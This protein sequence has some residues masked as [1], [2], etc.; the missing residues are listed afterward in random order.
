MHLHRLA[1]AGIALVLITSS[2]TLLPAQA[3]QNL[4]VCVVTTDK[5]HNVQA[6]Y[7]PATGDT[8]V[9]TAP[10][11]SVHRLHSGYAVT[12]RWYQDNES[13][14]WA[15]QVY[16]R[17]G[18][19]LVIGVNEL[20]MVGVTVGANVYA[21]AGVRLYGPDGKMRPPTVV[22]IPVRPGCEFHRYTLAEGDALVDYA[23]QALRK[24]EY[25]AAYRVLSRPSL[26]GNG[27]A[28]ARLGSLYH[29]ARGVAP[30][31]AA[32][33][34]L[35]ERAIASKGAEG[36]T[37]R[38]RL[39]AGSR[40][41]VNAV[42]AYR[43]GAARGSS[44]SAL[45][46]AKLHLRG[47]SGTVD[48]VEAARML[49][50]VITRSNPKQPHRAEAMTALSRLYA[51][52]RGIDGDAAEWFASDSVTAFQGDEASADFRMG[53]RFEMGWATWPD[54]AQAELHYRRGAQAGDTFSQQAATRLGISYR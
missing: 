31:T 1:T 44:E 26:A 18:L 29:F 54:R 30:D 46:L 19:P 47:Q 48:L 36:F 4:T 41:Y 24:G 20:S 28:L 42:A 23:E 25:P 51:A 53:R 43:A 17:S 14:V 38:G 2:V 7:D 6:T 52:G 34:R 9:G 45:E 27:R 11:S 37:G 50:M 12:H 22:Y 32:A 21:D 39:A 15:E 13:I 16:A 35:Y 8:L 10:F 49:R 40:D 3:R 5:L 33:R